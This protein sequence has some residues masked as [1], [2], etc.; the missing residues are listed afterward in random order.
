M[1]VWSSNAKKGLKM[2]F[3]LSKIYM[4]HNLYIVFNSYNMDARGVP[5]MYTAIVGN[6]YC[7]NNIRFGKYFCGLVRSQLQRQQKHNFSH[8][9]H[10]NI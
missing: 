2:P 4:P 9:H 6:T 7:M 1:T 3:V 5:D 10:Q 8:N